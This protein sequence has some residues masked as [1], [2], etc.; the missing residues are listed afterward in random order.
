MKSELAVFLVWIKTNRWL[1]PTPNGRKAISRMKTPRTEQRPRRMTWKQG[2][3]GVPLSVSFSGVLGEE[4][5]TFRLA[6]ENSRPTPWQGH[7]GGA[8]K[9]LGRN[10]AV[11]TSAQGRPRAPRSF[12]SGQSLTGG[13]PEGG[14]PGPKV[15][16]THSASPKTENFGSRDPGPHG[17]QTRGNY[18]EKEA[19]T[20]LPGPL[21][22]IAHPSLS[23][24]LERVPALGPGPRAP[25]HRRALRGPPPGRQCL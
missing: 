14:A 13:G 25:G 15:S 7:W 22:Q 8:G 20:G 23:C 17:V 18:A 3:A 21:R 6:G 4:A 5:L 1:P 19:T 11:V 12:Q 16:N 24:L 2:E 10:S 9:R